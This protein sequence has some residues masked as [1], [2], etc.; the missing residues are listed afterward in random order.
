[1]KQILIKQ[2]GKKKEVLNKKK[3]GTLDMTL[4]VLYQFSRSAFAFKFQSAK[5]KQLPKIVYFM[6]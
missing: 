6:G 1:M 4:L 3:K 5:M 2:G